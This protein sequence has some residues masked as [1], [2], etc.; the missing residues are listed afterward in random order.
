MISFSFGSVTCELLCFFGYVIF[1]PSCFLWPCGEVC[2][3][4]EQSPLPSFVDWLQWGNNSVVSWWEAVSCVGSGGSVI[5]GVQWCSLWTANI[6]RGKHCRGHDWIFVAVA[7]AEEECWGPRYQR[8]LGFTCSPFL[9]GGKFWL[10][11]SASSWG[12]VWPQV[13]TTVLD[14]RVHSGGCRTR[15]LQG[16]RGSWNYCSTWILGHG[17]NH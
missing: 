3:F 12:L 4:E 7:A 6:S 14:S 13:A 5:G 2:T 11:G 1:H 17:Y 16:L 10:R 15:V 8:L 9:Y